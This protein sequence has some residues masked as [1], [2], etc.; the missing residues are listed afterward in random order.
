[1]SFQ[2]S[3]LVIDTAADEVVATI[4][5]V[6]ER[7]WGIGITPDGGTIYTA[8]GPSDDVS[9]I[10]ARTLSVVARIKAGHSP[11]GIALGR[12]CSP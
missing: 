9:V 5:E 10:D 2:F 8:N 11:W 6:G 12:R 1:M 7:P 4:P 3:R